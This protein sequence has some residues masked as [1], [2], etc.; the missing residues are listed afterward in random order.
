M[1]IQLWVKQILHPQAYFWGSFFQGLV[2]TFSMALSTPL[3]YLCPQATLEGRECMQFLVILLPL[4]QP[5]AVMARQR[6]G[7][8]PVI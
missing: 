3:C 4:T 2:L 6:T 8:C 7:G 5:V 1:R